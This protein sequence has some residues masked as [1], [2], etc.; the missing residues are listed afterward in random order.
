MYLIKEDNFPLL[1]GRDWI[2]QFNIFSGNLNAVSVNKVRTS[3]SL[4]NI[5]K[6]YSDLFTNHVGEIKNVKA[7]LHLEKDATPIFCK[8]RTVTYALR[9]A[10]NEELQRLVNE[11]ILKPVTT[12]KWA[13]PIVPVVK[14]NGKI[15]LCGDFKVTVNKF[16]KV[17][18][19]PLP[20]IEDIL[21]TL[22]GGI[23]F[24]KIDLN[25]AYLH[26]PVDENSQ[27]LLTI[28]TPKGLFQFTRLPYCIASSPAKWQRTI[29]QILNGIE[30]VSVFI[31]DICISGETD[32]VH[33]ERLKQVFDRL[34]EYNLKINKEK[35]FFMKDE[36]TYCDYKVDKNGIH[37]TQEKVEAIL[38]APQP[39]NVSQVKAFLGLVSYYSRF[40]PN[41]STIAHPLNQLLRK[42]VRFK[43]SLECERAFNAIKNEITSDRVLT[44][45]N[46]KLPLVLATDASPYGISA[47][48]SHTMPDHSEKAIAFVSRTLS[49]DEK[50][51]SQVDKEALSII[52]GIKRFFS[53][54][55]R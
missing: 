17:D 45:F 37:K 31:D 25:Q 23:H 8:A 32:E 15:R 18:K 42:N 39:N 20:K 24:T 7:E 22:G 36:I 54:F 9:N 1:L 14:P 10:V 33:L 3:E 11:G 21:A 53:I 12:S 41:L 38:N 28:N 34:R 43:W 48:L 27:E 40:V 55:I 35:S 51:Y 44:H 13:T 52:F 6:D 2:N 4:R 19:Y 49:N 26:L 46:P 5:L 50:R 16:L 47:V 29:E 30:G